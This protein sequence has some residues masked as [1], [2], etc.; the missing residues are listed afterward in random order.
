MNEMKIGCS[1]LP[2]SFPRPAASCAVIEIFFP[3]GTKDLALMFCA[4]L[5][6]RLVRMVKGLRYH[7]ELFIEGNHLSY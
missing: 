3:Q 4:L 5:P 7:T 6:Y 1:A 2:C